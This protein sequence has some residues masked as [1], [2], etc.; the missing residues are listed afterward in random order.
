MDTVF[1]LVLPFAGCAV[2]SLLCVWMMRGRDAAG[3]SNPPKNAP[4]NAPKNPSNDRPRA[5]R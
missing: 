4:E 1:A 2:M 5:E 3:S